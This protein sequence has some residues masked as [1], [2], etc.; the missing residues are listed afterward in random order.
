M[1]IVGW[2]LCKDMNLLFALHKMRGISL[3]AGELR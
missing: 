1:W 3:V 2:P